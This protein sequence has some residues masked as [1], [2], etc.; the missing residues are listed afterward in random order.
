MTA[1]N[2]TDLLAVRMFHRDGS[3]APD[4]NPAEVRRGTFHWTSNTL[5]AC[6]RCGGL[7]GS[8]AWRHTGWVCYECNGARQLHYS[9]KNFSYTAEKLATMIAA[10]IKREA[11]RVERQRAAEAAELAAVQPLLDRVRPFSTL[12][13][14]AVLRAVA[15]WDRDGKDSLLADYGM[16]KEHAA[17]LAKWMTPARCEA[18]VAIGERLLADSVKMASAPALKPGRYEFAGLVRTIKVV[19]SAYGSSLK[20]L[21]ELPDGN[22]VWGTLPSAISN[23][24]K[25]DTVQLTATVEVKAGDP[26]FGFFSRPS[27]ATLLSTATV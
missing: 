22:R 5:E 24:D 1:T 4:R 25:G 27:K 9:R 7:G 17:Q 12:L 26:H 10:N 20:M 14:P 3:P 8:D 21:V 2:S 15:A 18:I 6:H 11:K 23:A 13:E 16:V 19:H